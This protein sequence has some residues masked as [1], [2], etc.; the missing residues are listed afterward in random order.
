M[1]STRGCVD[2]SHLSDEAKD[3]IMELTFRSNDLFEE[4][5]KLKEENKKLKAELKELWWAV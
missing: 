2:I 1:G 4:N 3:I 5:K